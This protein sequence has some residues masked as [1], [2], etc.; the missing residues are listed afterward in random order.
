MHSKDDVWVPYA[1]GIENTEGLHAKLISFDSMGH[2]GKLA[3]DSTMVNF[4]ELLKE[5][6]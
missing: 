1:A 5:L 6:A 4:P 2:F 3:D